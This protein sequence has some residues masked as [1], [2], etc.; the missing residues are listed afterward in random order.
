M[1]QYH[2]LPD[3]IIFSGIIP[4]AFGAKL[5]LDMHEVMPEFYVSKFGF[6]MSHP[7]VKVLKLLERMSVWFAHAVI[8]IN[9][10]IKRLLLKRCKPKSS[11]IVVMNT[12]D[13]SIFASGHRRHSGRSKGFIAMY[14]GTLTYLYGV[15]I[16]IRAIAKLK[17]KIPDLEFRIFGSETEMDKL[18]DLADELG[19]SDNVVFMGRVGMDAIP[20]YIAETDIGVVPTVK[21]GY[22]DLSFSNKL[23][24]YVSMKTPAVA[25]RLR[26]TL[27]YFTEDAISYFESRDVDALASK[28]LELYMNPQKRLLQAEKAFQQYQEIR[29]AVMKKRYVGLIESLA[30]R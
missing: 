24:E 5:V 20:K 12:A 2:T 19:V 23:A 10:P 22:I 27:E 30:G 1:I 4:K 11:I 29:W 13:E 28:I 18:K 17:G 9:D 25:T 16:A 26:S 6:G 8:V 7:L 15:D 21:D 3:F 14:H